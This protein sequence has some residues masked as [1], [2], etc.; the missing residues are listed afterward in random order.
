MVF[1]LLY[2][3]QNI[4]HRLLV[5]LRT[6]SLKVCII[7]AASVLLCYREVGL[8]GYTFHGHVFLMFHSD[9]V[10]DHS[11]FTIDVMHKSK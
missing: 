6:A 8:K 5:Y 10:F 4:K 3:A 2:I 9:S 7:I 11:L 1:L